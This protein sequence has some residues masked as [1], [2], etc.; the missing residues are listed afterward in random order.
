MF[1]FVISASFEDMS[2]S[3]EVAIEGM[4]GVNDRVSD[5]GLGSEVNDGVGFFV[6]EDFC[7][8]VE[9]FEVSDMSF[10]VILF[11]DI[12]SFFFEARVVIVI[13]VIDS[14]DMVS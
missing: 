7:N 10:D 3:D 1:S 13:E 12:G 11:E 9:V 2:E 4:E 5:A 6:F 14:G 8:F